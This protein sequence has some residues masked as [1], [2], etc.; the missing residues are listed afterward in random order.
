MLSWKARKSMS[1]PVKLR[2]IL[3]VISAVAW[4]II[5]PV[6]YAY[7]LESPTGL[8]RIMKGWVGNGQSQP[9][10]YYLAVVIY[11]SP[12][13]LTALLFL[14]PS[15]R[16]YLESSNYKIIMLMMW[17]SQVLELVITLIVGTWYEMFWL[18]TIIFEISEDSELFLIFF[19]SLMCLSFKLAASS[20]C[21]EGNAWR[22]F[23]TFYVRLDKSWSTI[24]HLKLHKQWMVRH[25]YIEKHLLVSLPGI[26]YS[27]C[28]SY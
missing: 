23:L 13:M 21:R 24:V 7:T 12:N 11:L 26:H 6:T 19:F 20:L 22:T 17:W 15:L 16:R 2:Y 25:V 4:V 8:G 28:C 10:I 18:V 14:F 9:S 5:L 1:L 27:G 3:K